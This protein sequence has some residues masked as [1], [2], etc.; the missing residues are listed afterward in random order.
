MSRV[1]GAQNVVSWYGWV[2]PLTP[3]QP[4][5]EVKMQSSPGI[6]PSVSPEDSAQDA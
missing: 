3:A 2:F 1:L 6:C 5:T 4:L